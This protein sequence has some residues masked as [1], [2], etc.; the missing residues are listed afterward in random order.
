MDRNQIIK[1]LKNP[2][3]MANKYIFLNPKKIYG[4]GGVQVMVQGPGSGTV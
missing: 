4:V 3:K 2:A 1:W